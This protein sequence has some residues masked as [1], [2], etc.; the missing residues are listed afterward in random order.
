MQKIKLAVAG[1]EAEGLYMLLQGAVSPSPMSST[2]SPSKKSHHAPPITDSKLPPQE[3]E[4]T[5]PEVPTPAVKEVELV[6]GA[7]SSAVTPALEVAIPAQ[8]AP[9]HLQLGESRGFI[10]ARWRSAVRSCPPHRL[11]SVHTCAEI[12][13]GLG[14]HVPPAPR[15]S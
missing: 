9:L 10:N 4:E 11:L 2:P 15:F 14:W 5:V 13:W 8:M 3:P 1:L 6:S 7:P 12:T